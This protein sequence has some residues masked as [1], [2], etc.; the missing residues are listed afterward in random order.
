MSYVPDEMLAELMKALRRFK[1][2]DTEYR[3]AQ[4]SGE[5][6]RFEDL[7]LLGCVAGTVKDEQSWHERFAA[8]KLRGE[9]FSPAASLLAA[10]TEALS[11]SLSV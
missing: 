2:A 7:R 5:Q 11:G 9:W 6:P 10:I 3:R 1:R 4:A 8:H